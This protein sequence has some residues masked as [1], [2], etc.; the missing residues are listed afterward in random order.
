MA[1][2]Q[3]ELHYRQA[4]DY[5]VNLFPTM[6]DEI[7][8]AAGDVGVLGYFTGARILDTVGLNSPQAIQYYPLPESLHANAYA[9]SPDLIMDA[10][11]DYVVILEVY[12]R[13]G[14][15]KDPRFQNEYVLIHKIATSSGSAHLQPDLNNP[16]NAMLHQW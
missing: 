10:A 14:L 6:P 8:L 4:A 9:V 5:L 11:P 2:Y 15:L 12:G 16:N 1:W 7:A 13:N 3:L